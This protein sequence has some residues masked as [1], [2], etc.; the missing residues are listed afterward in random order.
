MVC[1]ARSYRISQYI[2]AANK[3]N[4]R[5]VI[6]SDSKHSL[7]S[8]LANGIIVDFKYL[9]LAFELVKKAIHSLPVQAV[10]STDDI[11]A[12]LSSKIAAFLQLP[13][14]DLKA[15]Q[16][17]YRKD[18]ARKALKK[19]HCNTPDFQVIS[20]NDPDSIKQTLNYPVVIKPLMLSASKGVMRA[21]NS[22]DFKEKCL[23]LFQILKNEQ[24]YSLYERQHILVESY[25]DGFEV[26]IDGFIHHDK[27]QLLALF[28]KPEPLNGPYFE[29]S[30]YITPSQH[31]KAIQKAIINEVIRCCQAYGLS[32]GAIHAEVRVTKDGIFL[33]EMASRT[34]GGQ[35]AQLLEYSLG[36]KLEELILTLLCQKPIK[37]KHSA[38]YSG[39]LMIPITQ[40]GI[41]KRVE[42]LLEANKI[43]NIVD[44]EIHIQP[45]Y[46]L[47]PLPEGSSYLGFIFASSDDF[48]KTYQSLKQAHRKLVFVT[49]K[50]WAI[51]S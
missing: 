3:L 47:I 14:N 5:L 33:I 49:Q 25:L 24:Q 32:F 48:N 45:G 23:H 34:I 9:D 39:V 37:I 28:D 35:C 12:P 18:L 44:I 15:A 43:P 36:V 22:D 8:A 51:E 40:K 13:H 17:T 41:L 11:G 6:V 38:L 1:P 29:E 42:G 26:A 20:I 21:N 10:F 7:V 4:Y 31:P 30:Y 19:A 2:K 16:L 27:F 46:E 50:T